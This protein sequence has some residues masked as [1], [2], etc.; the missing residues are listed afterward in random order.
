[1]SDTPRTDIEI[2]QVE[3]LFDSPE[4]IDCKLAIKLAVVDFARQLER[5]NAELRKN[6]FDYTDTVLAML[7]AARGAECDVDTLEKEMKACSNKPSEYIAYKINE[8]RALVE[9]MREALSK[10]SVKTYDNRATMND[11]C[12]IADAALEAAERRDP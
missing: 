6:V 1:M 4:S 7:F 9:Q 11:I 5:E 10:I 12:K 3:N 8:L 2:R